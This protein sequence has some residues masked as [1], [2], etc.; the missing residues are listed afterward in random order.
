MFLTVDERVDGFGAQFQTIICCILLAENTGNE[1]IHRRIRSME[2]NYNNDPDYL[3]K[4]ELLMNVS[5]NYTTISYDDKVPENM[6]SYTPQVIIYNFELHMNRLLN[7]ESLIKLKTN[8]WKNKNRNIFNN[9]AFNIAI[10]IRS[11]NL[12]DITLESVRSTPLRYYF[13]VIERIKRN[14]IS[15]KQ[16]IFH[17]YS[18][19]DI[20]DYDEFDKEGVCF[21][22]N[23]NISDTFIGLV[24]ADILVTSKSAFSYSAAILSDGIIYYQP[25]HQPPGEKWIVC[26]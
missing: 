10:H 5:N 14:V 12:H 6:I 13:N 7:S 9:D 4:A 15:S 16:I 23:E 11:T 24:A 1:Y 18:Q 25:F 2:H 22:L 17:I 19:N 26:S 8:F 21:H 20:S 3:S